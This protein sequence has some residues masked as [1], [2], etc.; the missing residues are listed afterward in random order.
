MDLERRQEE[1]AYDFIRAWGKMLLV[2]VSWP[3]LFLIVFFTYLPFPVIALALFAVLALAW[4]RV[5]TLPGG[6]RSNFGGKRNRR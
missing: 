6:L 4:V 1:A 2:V 3:M 5:P